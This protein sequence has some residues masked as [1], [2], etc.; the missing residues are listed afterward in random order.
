[1]SI[2]ISTCYYILKSKFDPENYLQWCLNFV[3]LINTNN[4]K[5]VLYTNEESFEMLISNDEMKRHMSNPNIKIIIYEFEQFNTY[6]FKSKWEE[7][8]KNNHLLK[9]IVDWK[10]NMLWSEK[11]HMVK[12]TMDENLFQSDLYVW[13]DVGYFRNR[14]ND[15]NTT[16]LTTWLNPN[17]LTKMD[18]NKIYYGLVNNDLRYVQS[19]YS[20][21]SNKNSVGLPNVPLPLDQISVAGGFFIC[22]RDKLT[23]WHKC[24]YDKLR[25][26]FDNNY[27]VKDDQIILADC[28]FSN[29]NHF[30]LCMENDVNYDNW[31]MFQ[32][33]LS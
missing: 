18:N 8:H 2:T 20:L 1:M 14:Q 33:I 32:R 15:L 19:I 23:W 22:H 6:Q 7:N 10:V 26:Y 16:E 13:C 12:N 21:V 29:M 25:L 17:S 5:L 9:N 24:Y 31:F 28:I 3:S 11:I 30:F 4:F 27:L